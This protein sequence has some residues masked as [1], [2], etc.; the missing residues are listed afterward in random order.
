MPQDCPGRRMTSDEEEAVYA[1]TLDYR[2]NEGWVNGPAPQWR[3]KHKEIA[4]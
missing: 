4:A 3:R 1:G 2:E